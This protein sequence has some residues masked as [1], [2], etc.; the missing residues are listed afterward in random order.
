MKAVF[1]AA[2]EEERR[3]SYQSYEYTATAKDIP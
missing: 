3:F 2:V 1:T